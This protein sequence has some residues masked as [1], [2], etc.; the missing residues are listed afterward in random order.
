MP[1]WQDDFACNDWWIDKYSEKDIGI[2]LFWTRK[3][4]EIEYRRVT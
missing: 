1:G 3:D 4:P 2:A